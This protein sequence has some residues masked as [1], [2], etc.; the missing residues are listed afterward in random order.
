[1]QKELMHSIKT[2]LLKKSQNSVQSELSSTKI[3]LILN[4]ECQRICTLYLHL[5]QLLTVLRLWLIWQICCKSHTHL[6]WATIEHRLCWIFIQILKRA[7]FKARYECNTLLFICT[8]LLKILR[9][10][11][12]L[13]KGHERLQDVRLPVKTRD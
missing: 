1:M 13:N 7:F 5:Y 12:S 2:Q 10:L 8:S 9:S 3:R 11:F 4:S 6:L